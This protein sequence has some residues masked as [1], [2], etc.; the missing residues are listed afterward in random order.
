MIENC[1]FFGACSGGNGTQDA[2]CNIGFEG[3]LCA[4][5]SKDYYYDKAK[6][7]CQDCSQTGEST[8]N[9][10]VLF[11]MIMVFIILVKTIFFPSFKKSK[12]FGM[13]TK[14]SSFSTSKYV[15]VEKEEAKDNEEE[16]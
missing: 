14:L 8:F 6:N 1:V 13:I 2:L 7:G 4:V 10:V 9:L 3:P 15:V 5:C 12:G 11:I 16:T